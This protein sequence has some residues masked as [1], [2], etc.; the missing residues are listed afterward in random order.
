MIS[1]FGYQNGNKNF[2]FFKRSWNVSSTFG[3]KGPICDLNRENW[4]PP[5]ECFDSCPLC[6]EAHSCDW[7]TCYDDIGFLEVVIE[8]V[9]GSLIWESNGWYLFVRCEKI[10]KVLLISFFNF[11]WKI[12]LKHNHRHI[13][14]NLVFYTPAHW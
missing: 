12:K 11:L 3:S 6:D 5:N 14:F 4:P 7:T 1:K 10:S 9:K 13:L 8:T 2:C